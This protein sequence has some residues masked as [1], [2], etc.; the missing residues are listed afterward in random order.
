MT[1]GEAEAPRRTMPRAFNGV[2]YRLTTFFILGSLCVGIVVPYSD[3]FL[4]NALSD[5]TPGAGSSPYVI[6]MQRMHIPV[7]PHITNAIILTSIFS[8][9]NSYVF[10][11]SRTLFGLALEGK[12]PRV[13]A[14]CTKSGVPVYCVAVTLVVSLLGTLALFFTL[15]RKPV[16]AFLQ[17]S[18]NTAVVLQWLVYFT[19]VTFTLIEMQVCQPCNSLSTV[20]LCHYLLHL[21]SVL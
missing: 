15:V 12:A 3:P 13:L 11:A 7:L 20:E 10:C 2:F 6:A 16:L 19:S 4:L 17:V 21:H 1:A 14:K 9:G 5:A 18:N 8:A